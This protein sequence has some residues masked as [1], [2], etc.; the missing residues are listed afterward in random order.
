MQVYMLQ[1]RNQIQIYFF[2]KELVKKEE[3]FKR[4]YRLNTVLEQGIHQLVEKIPTAR[5]DWCWKSARMKFS[6]GQLLA[7]YSF[8]TLTGYSWFI[9]CS[10]FYYKI[11]LIWDY[12]N[13]QN[14]VITTI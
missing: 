3:V 8:F 7:I 5:R 2:L 1:I 13:F 12:F 14:T 4:Q 6:L 11:C 10:A 9:D